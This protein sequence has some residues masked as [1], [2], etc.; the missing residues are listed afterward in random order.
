[1]DLSDFRKYKH[2][3]RSYIPKVC[4]RKNGQIA[5]NSAAVAKYDLDIYEGV[6]LYISKDKKRVA[7]QFSN[8]K[9]DPSLIFIQ[10]RKGN[11]AFSAINFLGLNDIPWNKT[12]NFDFIWSDKDKIAIF[13][14]FDS[15][16]VDIVKNKKELNNGI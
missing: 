16:K 5:F 13:R 4:I 9:T 7:I 10:K 1:M 3:G 14:P 15:D 8:N 11:F 12:I 2:K 6:I